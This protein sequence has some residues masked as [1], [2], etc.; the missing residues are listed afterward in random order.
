MH[1]KLEVTNCDVKFKVARCDLKEKRLIMA[2]II[3]RKTIEQKIFLI[4]GHKV[5]LDMDLAKLYGVPTKV[6]NQAVKR[7]KKRFPAD[8]MF[9]LTKAEK[10]EVVT[11]CDH[12]NVLK[13]SPQLPYAFTEHGALML[14]NV[15]NNPVAIATGIAI[16]RAFARLRQMIA[17]YAELNEKIETMERRYDKQFRAVFEAIKKLLKPPVKEKR[18]IIGFSP[19]GDK[20]GGRNVSKG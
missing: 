16:V 18:R 10:E 7:N 5:M 9:R 1:F 14:A 17:E 2:E 15:I 8:F 6:L 11:N 20:K 13:F 19:Y 12:L 4:R 3:L